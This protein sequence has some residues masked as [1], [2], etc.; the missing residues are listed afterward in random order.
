KNP[1]AAV[2]FNGADYG[3][4]QGGH[5][6]NI[7]GSNTSGHDIYIAD[8]TGYQVLDSR[9]DGNPGTSI[10][11]INGDPNVVSGALIAGNVITGSGVNGINADGLQDSVIENNL[12]VG[13]GRYGIAL[14]RIDSSGPGLN[15]VIVNN[16]LVAG[17]GASGSFQFV[18]G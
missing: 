17:S 13:Y 15:N 2:H 3:V 12:I 10:V 4:F 8:G 16:T 14:Y 1:T 11:H 9:F 5:V 18:S 6:Y 7:G